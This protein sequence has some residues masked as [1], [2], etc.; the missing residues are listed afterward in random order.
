MMK[1]IEHERKPEDTF[2]D[3]DGYECDHVFVPGRK[4]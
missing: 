2:T 4:T 3:L 1:C